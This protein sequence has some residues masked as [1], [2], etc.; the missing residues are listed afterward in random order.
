MVGSLVPGGVLRWRFRRTLTTGIMALFN[1]SVLT[2][3][4][5]QA[6]H[7]A[8]GK[9]KP[10]EKIPSQGVYLIPECETDVNEILRIYN[11]SMAELAKEA[12][13]EEE[14]AQAPPPTYTD[15]GHSAPWP[16]PWA[17]PP[18]R[19]KTLQEIIQEGQ[20]ERARI[21][22]EYA[23]KDEVARVAR[24]ERENREHA[25]RIEQELKRTR[26][27]L[28]EIKDEVEESNRN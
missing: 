18:E 25:E 9:E 27:S 6:A 4:N 3:I 28:D 17:A 14:M 20:E 5:P 7:A 16:D 22:E 8:Q 21:E 15:P 19:T 23:R 13:Q 10:C 26:E 1:L 24:V 12:P 2:T 11:Q